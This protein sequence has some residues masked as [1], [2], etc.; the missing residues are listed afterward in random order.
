[1]KLVATITPAEDM[2]H[3]RNDE[4]AHE[5]GRARSLREFRL[6]QR[7]A[8]RAYPPGFDGD[9][10]DERE[11]VLCEDQDAYLNVKEP[12]RNWFA[13]FDRSRPQHRAAWRRSAGGAGIGFVEL[14]LGDSQ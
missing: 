5:A 6:N 13:P 11:G 10:T 2:R 9:Y 8:A 1:M 4:R 3:A 12:G 14:E 7:I